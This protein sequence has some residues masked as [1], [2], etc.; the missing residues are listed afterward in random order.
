MHI[1]NDEYYL[2][3]DNYIEAQYSLIDGGSI[4]EEGYLYKKETLTDTNGNAIVDINSNIVYKIIY[5]NSEGIELS[6]VISYTDVA[7]NE[8]NQITGVEK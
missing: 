2:Q 7:G 1:A 3:S 6:S 4:D 8:I 5:V